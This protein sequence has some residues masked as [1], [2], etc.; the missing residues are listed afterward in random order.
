MLLDEPTT[1]LD[2]WSQGNLI[3]FLLQWADKDKALVFSTQDL[4]V[5]EEVATRIIVMGAGHDIVADGSRKISSRILIFFFA[6]T[7]STNIHTDIRSWC[8]AI[9]ICMS[10]GM[11]TEEIEWSPLIYFVALSTR[12]QLNAVA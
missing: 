10:T 12:M 11:N 5:V 3:D 6:T 1:G 8:T 4:D 2:P 7:L 9:P